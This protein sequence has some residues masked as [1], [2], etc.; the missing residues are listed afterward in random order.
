[1]KYKDKSFKYGEFDCCIFA[2]EILEAAHEIS[3]N[4]PFPYDGTKASIKRLFR[5]YQVKTLCGL[6]EK[7]SEHY[8]WLEV[9][10]DFLQPYDLCLFSHSN[11]TIVG[12]WDGF[13]LLAPSKKGIVPVINHKIIKAFRPRRQL[14]QQ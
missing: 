12:I 10:K 4:L 8:H 3:I 13:K 7:L 9:K 2:K 1:M 14:C 6:I 5:Y 11:K